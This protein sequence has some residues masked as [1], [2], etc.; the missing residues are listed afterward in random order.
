M[1][2]LIR[3]IEREGGA[4]KISGAGALASHPTEPGG[5]AGCILVFHPDLELLEEWS[6]LSGL[7]R[8]DVSLGAPGLRLEAA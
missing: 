4:A 6:L 2:E 1:R 8:Y 7:R 3:E 5:G